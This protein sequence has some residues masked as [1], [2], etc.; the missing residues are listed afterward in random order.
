MKSLIGARNLDQDYLGSANNRKQELTQY[1]FFLSYQMRHWLKWKAG[2]DVGSR[3]SNIDR[4]K[5]DGN[6]YSVSV[7][8]VL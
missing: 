8:M 2:V 4:F 1:N 6:V 3:N 5:F 7:L